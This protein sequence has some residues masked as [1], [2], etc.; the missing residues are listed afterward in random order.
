MLGVV[1]DRLYRFF[2]E[3][4]IHAQHDFIVQGILTKLINESDTIKL[5]LLIED[6]QIVGHVLMALESDLGTPIIT[7]HQAEYDKGIA[8][9]ED[10]EAWLE[11]VTRFGQHH[12]AQRI[13]LVTRRNPRSFEKNWGFKVH[14]T[15]MVRDIP[16]TTVNP[17]ANGHAMVERS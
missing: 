17:M 12:N 7:I 2:K 8:N 16:Y 13:A 11:E 15:I 5:L 3:Y 6:N 4:D 9:K 10:K 14:R 1:Y